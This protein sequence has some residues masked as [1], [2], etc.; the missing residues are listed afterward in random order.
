MTGSRGN[1]AWALN[2]YAA[3]IATTGD[4]P[5]ALALYRQAL[6]MNRELSK[7]DDEAIALEGIGECHLAGGQAEDGVAHLAQA[8]EIYQRLGMRPDVERV[9]ARLAARTALSPA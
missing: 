4:R 7:P 2:Y 6:T 8:L 3:V 9:R 1:V 5:R